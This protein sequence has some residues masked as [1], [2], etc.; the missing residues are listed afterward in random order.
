M[1]AKTSRSVGEMDLWFRWLQA[2]RFCCAGQ[3]IWSKLQ[4]CE[5]TYHGA[6]RRE[7]EHGLAIVRVKEKAVF[8]QSV[9]H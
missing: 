8:S 9:S 3:S 6:N 7:E 5:L 2:D 4:E 1:K